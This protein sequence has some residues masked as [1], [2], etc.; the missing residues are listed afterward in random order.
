MRRSLIAAAAMVC[1]AVAALPAAAS[2]T[3]VELGYTSAVPI[4]PAACPSTV[5]AADCRIILTRST[6]VETIRAGVDYPTTAKQSGYIVAFTV[7]LSRLSTSL[8]TAHSEVANLD[9]TYGGTTQAAVAVLKPIGK[10]GLFTWELE[11]VGPVVHLQPFLGKVTQFPLTT[12][13]PIA[14]G[15]VVALSV[16]TWAPVLSIGLNTQDYAYRQDR[17]A[18]CSN[19]ASTEQAMFTLSATSVFGC[20]YT[21]VRVEYSATEITTPV[22]PKVQ[23]HARRGTV[24]HVRRRESRKAARRAARWPHG[25]GAAGL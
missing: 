7:G 16:P 20:D 22:P 6:A 21:G 3:T 13:L 5:N 19:P 17:K 1:L 9:H 18:N 8:A 23:V 24:R 12:A 11:A 2:A 15:D 10:H 25:D 14:K 4:A